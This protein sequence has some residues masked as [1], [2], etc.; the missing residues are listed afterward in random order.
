L[1]YHGSMEAYR[2]AKGLLFAQMGNRFD[3][4]PAFNKYAVLNV[5]DEASDYFTR[6]TAAQVVTYGIENEADIRATDIQITPQGSRFHVKTFRGSAEIQMRLIG[7]FNVYNALSAIATALIEGIP[8]TAIKE[9]L[10][11]MPG[12]SGRFEPVDAG[13]DFTVVVDYAHTPDSLENVLKTV[14]QFLK[15]D[16]ITVVGCGGDRDRSKRPVMGKLA[17]DYSQFTVVTSDNPRS[18]SPESIVRDVVAG[19]E[20]GGYASDCYSVIVDRAHAIED[21]IQRAK[22]GDVVVIA[23]KGH[24]TYQEINGVKYDFDDRAVAREAIRRKLG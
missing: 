7:E 2:H 1:D 15:G 9:S 13:Q 12:V 4:H 11:L 20:S 16:L 6:I 8:L 17:A 14:H 5:D 21:A 19:I 22:P 10:E 23:G 18:E 3:I 24:E